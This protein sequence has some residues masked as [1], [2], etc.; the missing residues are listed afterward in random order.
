MSK[1]RKTYQ[2]EWINEE[3]FWVGW[4]YCVAYTKAE[5]RKVAKEMQSP[6]RDDQWGRNKGMYF[7]NA[8]LRRVTEEQFQSTWNASY[9]D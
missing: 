6:A 8:S 2:W 4:N 5:A 3:G 9:M 7:N 1:I